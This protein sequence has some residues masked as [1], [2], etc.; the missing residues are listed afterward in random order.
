MDDDD[1]DDED[2]DGAD[3]DFKDGG[4]EPKKNGITKGQ[5]SLNDYR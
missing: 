5:L 3:D 1:G 4:D 2:E